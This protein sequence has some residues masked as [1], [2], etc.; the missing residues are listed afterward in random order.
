MRVAALIRCSCELAAESESALSRLDVTSHRSARSRTT[1]SPEHTRGTPYPLPPEAQSP[2]SCCHKKRVGAATCQ[3]CAKRQQRPFDLAYG[4]PNAW[5]TR[6]CT[7][8]YT[9]VAL[10]ASTNL[11]S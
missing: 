2:K 9:P 6:L 4:R 1:W 10:I 11:S 8:I 3:P 7:D 5:P